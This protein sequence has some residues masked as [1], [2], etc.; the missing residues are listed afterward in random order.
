MKGNTRE[1]NK[2]IEHEKGKRIREKKM[3]GRKSGKEKWWDVEGR[4]INTK[5]NKRKGHR[6]KMKENKKRREG[7]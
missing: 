7:R 6:E 5:L 3:L 2:G 1:E 4:K